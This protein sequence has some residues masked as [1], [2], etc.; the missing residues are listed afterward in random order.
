MTGEQIRDRLHRGV[1]VWGTH[2]T[3]AGNPVV[4]RLM[5]EAP[6]DFVFLCNEHMPLDRAQTSAL[7]QQF[8]E[9]PP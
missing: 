9:N 7:C 4:T 8:E 6:L 3:A 2:V 5:S 1:R